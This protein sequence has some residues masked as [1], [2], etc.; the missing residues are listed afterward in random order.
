MEQPKNTVLSKTELTAVDDKEVLVVQAEVPPHFT[1]TGHYHP[2]DEM[3][4]IL[5]GSITFELEGK[6]DLTLR[7][8]E[9]GY[10]PAHQVHFGKTGN[11][12]AKF[13][14]FQIQRTG[15]SNRRM[16]EE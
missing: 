11:E 9:S 2:G 5:E 6:P 7:A 16:A 15:E 10:I 13:L 12:A 8:G 1:G 3:V 4:Y 14:S